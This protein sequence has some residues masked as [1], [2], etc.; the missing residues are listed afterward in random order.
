[1]KQKKKEKEYGAALI[2]MLLI[3]VILVIIMT[4]M[5]FVITNNS[6]LTGR[7]QD[8]C[9]AM[10]VAEAGVHYALSHLNFNP[11]WCGDTDDGSGVYKECRVTLPDVG[12]EFYI[13]FNP[14]E[15]YCSFNNL[16]K[17]IQE[18]RGLKPYGNIPPF[19]SEIIVKGEANNQVKYIR[20]V[21]IRGDFL[22]THMSTE[23]SYFVNNATGYN[24]PG[25]SDDTK[26]LIITNS[27]GNPSVYIPTQVPVNL[28]EGEIVSCGIAQVENYDPALTKVIDN[29]PPDEIGQIPVAQILNNRPTDP[30]DICELQPGTYVGK[31]TLVDGYYQ[32]HIEYN[33]NTYNLS[34]HGNWG[35]F[36]PYGNFIIKK[37]LY[38]P[39]DSENPF[40]LRFDYGQEVS[41]TSYKESPVEIPAIVKVLNI[42]VAMAKDD[43]E[44]QTRIEGGANPTPTTAPV[45]TATA[46]I[47]PTAIPTPAPTLTPRPGTTPVPPTITPEPLTIKPQVI[48][49][50][51]AAYPPIIY[52]ESDLELEGRTAGIGGIVNTRKT[53]F[54]GDDGNILILN[55]DDV[56]LYID[57][58][59]DFNGNGLIYSD[60]D[61]YVVMSRSDTVGGNWNFGGYFVSRNCNSD[62]NPFENPSNPH[63]DECSMYLDLPN[64]NIVFGRYVNYI[65]LDMIAGYDFRVK[66]TSWHEI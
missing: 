62:A 29:A 35:E 61:V 31:R 32:Y 50:T 33:G 21:M 14:N 20:A 7:Y 54:M 42:P 17:N 63:D 39:E 66:L 26:G 60:D 27:A 49:D 52:S 43:G 13:T 30:N 6:H 53:S 51:Q 41:E 58:Y 2:S 28:H 44:S 8:T 40:I 22:G 1:M 19:T 11:D 47:P 56:T 45:P 15:E 5:A 25:I 34:D 57:P 16:R 65:P 38:I 9:V 48:F 4:S 24:D 3:L 36:D 37:N 46:V 18:V 64:K 23:G 55:C 10:Q 12:G 59:R